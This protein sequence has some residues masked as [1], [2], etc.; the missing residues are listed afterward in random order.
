[1]RWFLALV[2]GLVAVAAVSA[3]V[4]GGDPNNAAGTS[5]ATAS[6]DQTSASGTGA[7]GLKLELSI[8][9]T[10]IAP[11]Q[12]LEIS[13]GDYNTLSRA[14]NLSAADGWPVSYLS[15]G[16]CGDLNYPMG[17]AVVSGN[18]VTANVSS[19]QPL[20]LYAPGTYFCP[21]VVGGVKGYDFAST[22]STAEVYAACTPEPCLQ[23]Q[24]NATSTIQGYW[25]QPNAT[26]MEALPAGVYT[27][28]A[29]DEWG[30]LVVLHFSVS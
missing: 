2:L 25:P 15:D 6:F 20:A 29:G 14:N 13:L 3:V 8:N 19:A 9:T 22:N 5:P 18:Y 12:S 21:L 4:Y 24:T 16:P 26:A 30:N 7:N 1:M 28:V 11:G 10:S 27:V 23:I 17:F